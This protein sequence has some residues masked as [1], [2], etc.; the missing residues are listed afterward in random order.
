MPDQRPHPLGLLAFGQMDQ[1]HGHQRV[2]GQRRQGVE[3]PVGLQVLT[4]RMVQIQV[5]QQIAEGPL[6]V[7]FEP[8]MLKGQTRRTVLVLAGNK[9][10]THRFLDIA[11]V[12]QLHS[13]YEHGP[14]VK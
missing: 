13:P 11:P 14:A 1:F 6:L 8:V 12:A 7:P 3:H 4:W 5:A 10:V 9:G 2:V